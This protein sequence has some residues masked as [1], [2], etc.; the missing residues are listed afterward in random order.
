MLKVTHDRYG[1]GKN[2][3][4]VT[5]SRSALVVFSNPRVYT[6]MPELQR[7]E[8][9][10]AL[11]PHGWPFGK[12]VAACTGVGAMIEVTSGTATTAASPN[13]LTMSRRLKPAAIKAGGGVTFSSSSSSRLNCLSANQ[14]TRSSTVVPSCADSDRLISLTVICPS[15]CFHTSAAVSFRQ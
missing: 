13:T 14:I 11:V 6:Q 15:H 4:G 8:Q 12:H 3:G 5:S 2:K 7:P 1:V 9:H 10:C